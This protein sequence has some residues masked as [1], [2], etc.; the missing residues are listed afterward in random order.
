MNNI[1]KSEQYPGNVQMTRRCHECTEEALGRCLDCHFGFCQAHFPKHQHSPCAEKQMKLAQIQVCYV[2]G[3]PVYP[4]QWSISPTS[5]YIDEFTCH[6]CGRYICNELHT[7]QKEEEVVV[8]RD[9]LRGHRYQ[10]VIRYCDLCGPIA[11]VNG[12][13]GL[14]R[15]IVIAGTIAAFVFFFFHP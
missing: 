5:H 14:T 7:Q 15:L 9:G 3:V 11:R 10:C 6:G 4:D 2:C 8:T 1:G 12:I 13:R